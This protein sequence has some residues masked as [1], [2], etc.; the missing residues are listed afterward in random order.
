MEEKV[1]AIAGNPN[2]GKTTTFNALTGTRQ[3]VGN[4]PGVTVEKK[5]GYYIY[6][7]V[8]FKVVDLP[9]TYTLTGESE[10][11]KIAIDFLT[12]NQVDVLLLMA[13]AL[14]LERSMYFLI[15]L[16][17][18]NKNI[19][20]D[21]NMV[22]LAEK[23]GIDYDVKHLEKL[24]K[25][26]FVK[27]IGN[28]NIGFEDLKEA[29]YR[30]CKEP[31]SSECFISN[32]GDEIES[33][34][35][36]IINYLK[37][38]NL[39]YPERF[40]ALKVLEKD[41]YFV[42]LIINSVNYERINN[43][44]S[45]LEKFFNKPIER[46]LIEK[47]YGIIHGVVQE[48]LIEKKKELKLEIT[49]KL[50]RILTNNFLGPLTFLFI[51]FLTFT[52]VFG[53]GKPAT[54]FLEVVFEKFGGIAANFPFPFWIN[55]LIKDGI[56]SGVGSVV[57]FLPNIF[58]F[59]FFFSVLED[60]GYM[61][62]AAIVADRLMHKIGLHGKSAIPLIL[63]F[64]C[65][66][67]AI[68]GTRI[69]ENKRD[70]IL[71]SLSIPFMSCSARLPVYLLFTGIF[72]QENQGL[73][74]F[75]LYLFGIIAGILSIKFFGS[76]FFK[77]ESS[78]L[79]IE[80]PPFRFP[81]WQGVLVESWT[82]TKYFLKKAGTIIFLGALILW[83]LSYFPDPTKY[84]AQS[85]FIGRLGSIISPLFKFSGFGFWQASVALIF[86]IYAKELV[87]GTFGILFGV[88]NL[89]ESLKIY[90][91]TASAYS[92]MIMSLLYMPCLA[93]FLVLKKE[94]GMKWAIVSL[95]WSLFIGWLFSIL[96]YQILNF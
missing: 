59:F 70:K 89:M 1:I 90:F 12:Q 37:N 5:E 78:P 66:V 52:F 83:F 75:S 9:G 6:K 16:S 14:N 55:S 72:F 92:F 2:T 31:V 35:S 68:M 54:K 21:L 45:R 25:V 3:Q 61:S 8:K 62:R 79:I 13:D 85:N 29:I 24:L 69:L 53:I 48:A 86:G 42:N 38:L 96:F 56:V 23:E 60:T 67:P 11:Q 80:L 39:P 46:V 93:T 63:G 44:I 51:M 47:R 71:T 65:N 33:A 41:E 17:E 32:Y 94:I 74:I 43:L 18:L 27:T 87:V 57:L 19:I 15:L 4:W 22:D 49:E 73:I 77:K 76:T 36:E 20:V 91:T 10:D 84:G 58:L 28:K 26:K 64:G 50:D 88:G 7:G 82:K 30:K 40:V 81:Y 95:F 34:I